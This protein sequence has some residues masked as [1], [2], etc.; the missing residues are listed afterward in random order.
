MTTATPTARGAFAAM[1]ARDLH[2]VRHDAVPTFLRAFVQPVLFLFVFVYVLPR[3]ADAPTRV[4]DTDYSTIVATGMV[5]LP[6]MFQSFVGVMVPLVR[7]L[8]V[9][10]SIQ[11]RVLAPLPVRT[12]GLQKIVAGALQGVV[13]SLLVMPVTLVAGADTSVHNWPAFA[14]VLVT[15]SLAS[16]S[17]AL[18]VATLIAP[19]HVQQLFTVVILPLSMLGCVYFPWESLH[20]IVWL[21]IV[22]LANPVIYMSEGMRAV[23]TPG[24]PH[25]SIWTCVGVLAGTSLGL[26]WLATRQFERR[27]IA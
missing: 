7:E 9:E 2:I 14:A 10:G 12:L 3:T 8:F 19:Q 24:T 17:I 27:V 16:A 15:G 1:L 21:Q 6:L 20:R 26:G 4:A 18:L 13:A 5:A 11:D 23:L 25:L 22:V